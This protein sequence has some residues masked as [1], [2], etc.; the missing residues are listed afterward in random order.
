MCKKYCSSSIFHEQGKFPVLFIDIFS[1]AGYNE[2]VAVL[3]TSLSSF[4]LLMEMQFVIS[5]GLK[6]MLNLCFNDSY[7]H[8]IFSK[9]CVGLNIDWIV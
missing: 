8:F 7:A 1:K 9:T 2:A 5:R 6:T 4:F 3:G